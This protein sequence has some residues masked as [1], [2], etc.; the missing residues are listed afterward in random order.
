MDA[1]AELWAA[2]QEAQSSDGTKQFFFFLTF[3]QLCQG[4]ELNL[5]HV[6]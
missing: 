2:V 3:E 4:V 1:F 5:K 6:D